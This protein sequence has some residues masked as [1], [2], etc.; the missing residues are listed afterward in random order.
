MTEINSKLEKSSYF[1]PFPDKVKK[2]T[3]FRD[4]LTT[5]KNINLELIRDLRG[6]C[7]EVFLSQLFRI[8]KMTTYINSKV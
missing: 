3:L 8:S 6:N 7:L 1:N 2:L 4:E 5:D